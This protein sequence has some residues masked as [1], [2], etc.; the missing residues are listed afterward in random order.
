MNACVKRENPEAVPFVQRSW[1]PSVVSG[2]LKFAHNRAPRLIENTMK[3]AS[4]PLATPN[5]HPVFQCIWDYDFRLFNVRPRECQRRQSCCEVGEGF[6]VFIT[7]DSWASCRYLKNLSQEDWEN[8]KSSLSSALERFKE[9]VFI[10]GLILWHFRCRWRNLTFY[11]HGE[12]KGLAG[13]SLRDS[14]S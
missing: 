1:D 3:A 2:S 4:A 8:R 13:K 10:L 14:L 11:R 5:R 9:S 6:L 12:G 7:V